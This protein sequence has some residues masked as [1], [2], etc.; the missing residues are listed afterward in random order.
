MEIKMSDINFTTWPKKCAVLPTP[1]NKQYN[2]YT[3]LFE[4]LITKP[5]VIYN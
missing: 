3:S 5:N 1:K 2:A 4:L